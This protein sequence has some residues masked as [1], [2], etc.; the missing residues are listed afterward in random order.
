MSAIA[1]TVHGAEGRMGRLV[2]ELVE[3]TDGLELAGLITEVGRGREAGEFHPRIPL[4][5]QDRLTEIHPPRRRHRRLL[6][7]T[8]LDGL[9]VAAVELNAA[10]VVGTT[11]HS[12]EQMNSLALTPRSTA[13]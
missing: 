3:Q 1:V 9:L 6:A 4:T 7:R 5:P 10:L 12:D 8:A 11:G 2:T 13:S